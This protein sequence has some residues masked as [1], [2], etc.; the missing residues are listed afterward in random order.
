[1]NDWVIRRI[2]ALRS[3]KVNIISLI[4]KFNFSNFFWLHFNNKGGLKMRRR[5]AV[6][7]LI[8]STSLS[9]Q[10]DT[11]FSELRGIDD[12]TGATHLFYRKYSYQS[13]SP[14]WIRHNDIYHFDLAT[15]SDTLMFRDY[16]DNTPTSF[17]GIT[18]DDFEFLNYLPGH[19]ISCGAAIEVDPSAYFWHYDAGEIYYSLG[20]IFTIEISRQNDSLLYAY[21]AITNEGLIKS[22]D[23]GYNWFADPS[24]APYFFLIALSPFDDHVFFSTKE[25]SLYKS[26]D[27]GMSYNLVDSS[28]VWQEFG[29]SY[30]YFDPDSFHIYG[31]IQGYNQNHFLNSADAGDSWTL[32][33]S[34]SNKIY[35]SVDRSQSGTVFLSDSKEIKVS[36]DYGSTFNPYWQLS[37][38]VVGLYKKPNSNILYA[39]TTKDIYEITPTDTVSIKHLSTIPVSINGD[40]QPVI[41]KFKLYQ[42]YP[43][44]F[45]PTTTIR[46]GLP[47]AA[48]VRI[49]VFNI[50]GQR[51]AILLDERRETGYQSVQ[52][53]AGQLAS[54]IYFYRLVT[55][56]YADLKKMI[57]MR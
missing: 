35:L 10:V 39:A 36:E 38:P 31:I 44:P 9:S 37:R 20:E 45:N 55:E 8:L 24:A 49:E 19:F 50:R 13:F 25:A 40:S 22:T 30:L 43:N 2:V 29:D 5:V 32:L 42:N 16:F 4:L 57:L 3:N 21:Q 48:H 23:G 17:G 15:Q 56:N 26:V 27:R 28:V 41:W 34:D 53:D 51:V 52:F 1:L 47:K 33:R 12:S 54:G 7:I 46:F 18:T 11:T 14:Y 6:F